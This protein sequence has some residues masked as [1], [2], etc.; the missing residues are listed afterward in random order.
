[1]ALAQQRPPAVP[2]PLL[3]PADGNTTALLQLTAGSAVAANAAS[4]PIGQLRSALERAKL[5]EGLLQS[6]A[7]R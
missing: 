1:M 6:P 3:T 4:P 2:A 7:E 5:I